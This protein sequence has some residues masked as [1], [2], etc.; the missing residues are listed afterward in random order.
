MGWPRFSVEMRPVI[1]AVAAALA[2]SSLRASGQTFQTIYSFRGSTDGSLPRSSLLYTGNGKLYGTTYYGGTNGMGTV[3]ELAPSQSGWKESVIF[4]FNGTDGSN[5]I[6]GVAYSGGVLYGTTYIGGAGLGGF[7]AGTV[8]SLTPPTAPSGGWTEQVLYSF[9]GIC[10]GQSSPIGPVLVET[11]GVLIGT[12]SVDGCITSNPSGGTV[13]ALV[14]SEGGGAWTEHVLVDFYRSAV[15]NRPYSGFVA[16]GGAL[17]GTTYLSQN[18]GGCGMVYATSPSQ[19][20]G[21]WTLTQVHNFSGPDGCNSQSGLTLGKS[22]VLYGATLSGGDA[23]P[24][25]FP[26]FLVSGCGTVFQ[27]TPPASPGGSWTETVLYSFAGANGDGAYPLST[28][29]IGQDGS[30]YGTTQYGGSAAAGS[31]CSFY[32]ATG[33]GT[34]FKLTPPSAPGGAWTE[35]VLHSFTGQGDDGAIPSAGLAVGP[36]GLLYGTTSHGGAGS[37]GT[38][39]AVAP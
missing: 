38:V 1:L 39:F 14:P 27:L 25:D 32:G 26:P 29:V 5:P 10:D 11:G 8:F 2:F 21:S 28:L 20:G 15:G 13:F 24:C 7:G 36:K 34:V 3:Y 33:C 6:A 4:S 18:G 35:T 17:F 12:T 22:G 9:P 30:L 31:H 19:S 16:S 37:Q 23:L